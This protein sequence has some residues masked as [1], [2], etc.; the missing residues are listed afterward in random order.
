MNKRTGKTS[1]QDFAQFQ[2]AV[3]EWMEFFGLY[4]WE[5]VFSHEEIKGFFAEVHWNIKGRIATFILATELPD[6]QDCLE[7]FDVERIAFHEVCHLLFAK[8]DFLAESR[9]Y[10]AAE[11]DMELHSLIRIFEKVIYKERQVNK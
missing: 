3:K 11:M 4:N 9:N 1:K 2:K 7:H 8:V 6:L 5:Y 10:S